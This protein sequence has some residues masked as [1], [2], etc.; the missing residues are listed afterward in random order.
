MEPEDDDPP[1]RVNGR[2]FSPP[3]ERSV[4][5]R[6]M[7]LFL[8]ADRSHGTYTEEDPEPGGKRTIKRTA[9]T[10]RSPV[11]VDLWRQHLD[12]TRP[13]GV[14]PIRE[15]D[16]CWWGVVDVDRY[17]IVGSEIASL[18]R[19]AEIPAIC[20][21]SKSR[22]VQVYLFFSEPIPATEVVPRLRE[23]AA[24]IGHGDS[25]IFP[26]QTTVLAERGDLGS[27]LN[28]PYFGGDQPVPIDAS[29]PNAP[30]RGERWAILPDGR[31]MSTERF[32][33]MAEGNRLSRRGL[34]DLALR[35]T[36]A[37]FESGPPCLESLI[38][39]GFPEHTRNNG[40]LAL[41]ILAKK[42]QPDDWEPLIEKWVREYGGDPPFAAAELASV[43]RSVRK[44]DY[45]Y[46]C[47]DRPLN[48]RCN[49]ALCKTRPFGVGGGSGGVSLLEGVQILATDPP[50]FFLYL[51]TDRTVELSAAQLL[52]PHEFQLAVLTQ[53][54][55]VV[56]EYKRG[57]WLAAVGAVM[58]RAVIIEAPR[59]SG[60]G[61]RGEVRG[62]FGEILEQ[63]LTD[64]HRADSREEVL[65]GKPWCDEENGSVHFRLRDL[66]AAL[67]RSRF[68]PPDRSIGLRSWI[69][70]RIREMGGDS[71][72]FYARGRNINV[73]RLRASLFEWT[74]T[75]A[76]LPRH[77]ESPL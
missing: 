9:R 29:R 53:H 31:G 61:K 57:D 36:V 52:S 50:V 71:H 30:T 47:N 11:T 58:E 21:W 33:R 64:R 17:P 3:D 34:A 77:E 24:L 68:A 44:R 23:L 65:L 8:G 19:K 74:D 4:A 70:Q 7:S 18:L 37:G 67:E 35:T 13:L 14:V 55:E 20:C 66:E 59:E 27:W 48:M 39:T 60:G 45:N 2:K 25:E 49:V 15:D 12:G 46:K 76:A 72:Q 1:A 41:A 16:H 10:I 22:G 63:F 62:K 51:K 32:L 73:W 54:R 75:P 28:M 42:M 56:P 40:I 5:E 38:S 69:T 6:F 43:V 26:K